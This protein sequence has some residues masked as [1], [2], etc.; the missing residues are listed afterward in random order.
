[1]RTMKHYNALTMLTGFMAAIPDVAR[2]T[3]TSG[4]KRGF[5]TQFEMF[6]DFL[7]GG[8]IY[9]EIRKSKNSISNG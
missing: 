4:V 5:R 9:D 2:I 7:S 6:S 8:K 1:M 3:M